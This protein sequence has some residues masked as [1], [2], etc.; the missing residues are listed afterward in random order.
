MTA[1]NLRSATLHADVIDRDLHHEVTAGHILGP[2]PDKP[3][4]TLQCSGLGVVPKKNGKWRVIMHLSAPPGRSV[5]DYIP[6][7]QFTLTYATV[8]D[9]VRLL[10]TLG[11]DALMAKAD[12]KAAFRNIPT[13]PA[14]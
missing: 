1:R 7:E 14:D 3:L 5:N 11:K 4:P 8:D 2:F 6:R 12:L 10:T 13:N 9:A